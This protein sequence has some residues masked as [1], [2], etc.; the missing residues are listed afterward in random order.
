MMEYLFN[1]LKN[2]E[3][4]IDTVSEMGSKKCHLSQKVLDFDHLINTRA[5]GKVHHSMPTHVGWIVRED[6]KGH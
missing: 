4:L 2:E 5:S 6:N 3:K 1:Y